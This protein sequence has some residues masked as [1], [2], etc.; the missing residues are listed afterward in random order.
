MWAS[1][2]GYD[3]IVKTLLDAGADVD[4][5]NEVHNNDSDMDDVILL[6]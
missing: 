5:L 1:K 2:S 6:M 4:A 3:G